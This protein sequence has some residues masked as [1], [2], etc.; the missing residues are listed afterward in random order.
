MGATVSSLLTCHLA[1]PQET[2]K[3]ALS[4]LD[5][6]LISWGWGQVGSYSQ[7]S[8]DLSLGT[9]PRDGQTGSLTVGQS[10]GKS[11]GVGEQG[12]YSQQSSDLSLGTTPRDSQTG[13]LTVG[14]S[15]GKS[16]GGGEQGATVSSLLTCHWALVTVAQSS[17][18][19]GGGGEQWGYSQQSSQLD[20]AGVS[21]GAGRVAT[22]SSL[23]TCHMAL[24][25]ET[26]K[27][28]LS[29]LDIA[30]ISLR[31]GAGRGRIF[32]AILEIA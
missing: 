28:V 31:S 10:S 1:L 24:P 26:A 12:G 11:G 19:S 15:S 32:E 30:R 18:K 17:G 14:Q 23:L 9:A 16:G 25:R 6:A 3:Q 7:Q 4:Q 29:Q 21:R 2:A 8:S 20:K 22:V 13:S 5:K 27:E